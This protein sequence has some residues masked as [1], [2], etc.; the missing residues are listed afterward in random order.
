MAQTLSDLDYEPFPDVTA[1]IPELA[2]AARLHIGLHKNPSP[3]APAV[4]VDHKVNPSK[5]P[6]CEGGDLNPYA[7]Y[8]A[9]TS[10]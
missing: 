2:E 9:S 8:G 3:G 7:S 4:G 1:A 6:G 5:L 10:S